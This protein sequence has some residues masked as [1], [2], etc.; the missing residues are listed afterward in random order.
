M[1]RIADIEA[2]CSGVEPGVYRFLGSSGYD[3]D[4]LGTP[5]HSS[6]ILL[7][8]LTV[9]YHI[10]ILLVLILSNSRV[11]GSGVQAHYLSIACPCEGHCCDWQPRLHQGHCFFL[12][13]RGRILCLSIGFLAHHILFHDTEYES[14]FR[15]DP[16]SHEAFFKLWSDAIFSIASALAYVFDRVHPGGR[17]APLVAK[18]FL[19][20][21]I[22][23]SRQVA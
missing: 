5:T 22:P 16:I 17:P 7:F 12:G 9:S 8:K 23:I 14:L 4:R 10:Q 21:V 1:D 20:L 3:L 15:A 19:R 13:P 18:A 11:I 2:L 6:C